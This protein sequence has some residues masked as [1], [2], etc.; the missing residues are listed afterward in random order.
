[1]PLLDIEIPSNHLALPE[2]VAAFLTDA[3]QRINRFARNRPMGLT[4]FVPSDFVAVYH[5]LGA[6]AESN[7]AAGTSFCEWGSGFGV[8]AALA[9]MLEFRVC[10]IEIDRDLVDASRRL[11]ED[12]GLPVELVHGS[13]IPPGAEALAEAAFADQ[14]EDFFWLVT[15]ADQTYR[16]LGLEP[17]DFDVIFAYPWPSEEPLVESLFEKYAAEGA[18][19]LTHNKDQSVRLRRKVGGRCGG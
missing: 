1:M 5:A 9:A 12:F 19:L 13:F 4:G 7:L 11:A 14:Q 16:Q 3:D 17:D 10:G 18:L 6:I 2:N 8:V 15:D